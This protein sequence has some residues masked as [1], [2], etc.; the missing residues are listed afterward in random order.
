[1]KSRKKFRSS[2]CLALFFCLIFHPV[3]RVSCIIIRQSFH[4]FCALWRCRKWEIEVASHIRGSCCKQICTQEAPAY[5]QRT[6]R[7]PLRPHL[8]LYLL[9][10]RHFFTRTKNAKVEAAARRKGSNVDGGGGKAKNQ[11]FHRT[12][13][14]KGEE[15]RKR[16]G[17]IPLSD[18]SP[19]IQRR[20][21]KSGQQKWGGKASGREIYSKSEAIRN[22]NSCLCS[23]TRSGQKISSLTR[24]SHSHS[25]GNI[26]TICLL[27]CLDRHLRRYRVLR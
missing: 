23:L 12:V 24:S 25:N 17:K 2:A 11:Y 5:I 20:E 7:I 10:S 22:G 3:V 1:M 26:I 21:K 4:S 13:S 16:P 18:V 6:F 27:A 19:H 9:F 15:R 8:P 14:R